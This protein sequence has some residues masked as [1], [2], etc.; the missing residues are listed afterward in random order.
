MEPF[1]ANTRTL[2]RR[3]GQPEV[4]RLGIVRGLWLTG[5]A[6]VGEGGRHCPF[7]HLNTIALRRCLVHLVDAHNT[8]FV[9]GIVHQLMAVVLGGLCQCLL[10]IVGHSVRRH[11]LFHR[12]SHL[13]RFNT[14]SLA[15]CRHHAHSYNCYG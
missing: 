2:H 8:D 12:T 4:A 13:L 5:I 14:G 3:A 11:R 6:D 7:G 1:H 10:N 9:C 15:S